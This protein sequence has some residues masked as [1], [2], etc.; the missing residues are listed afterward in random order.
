MS[1]A[2]AEGAAAA[3]GTGAGGGVAGAATVAGAGSLCGV[4]V[5]GPGLWEQAAVAT[6]RPRRTSV[7]GA[8]R[9]RALH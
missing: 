9:M 5:S 6:T 2:L 1:M 7:S 4:V 3:A 8:L